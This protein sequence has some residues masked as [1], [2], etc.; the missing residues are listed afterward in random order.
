MW[1][2]GIAL[3]S[4]GNVYVSDEALNRV[5]VFSGKGEFVHCWGREGSGEDEFNRPAGIAFDAEDNLLVADGLNCRVQRYT[6]DGRRLGGWGRPGDADGEMNVPWGITVDRA[7]NVY[8]SDWRNDRIQKFGRRRASPEHLGNRR[9]GRRTA[10]AACRGR[11]RP[12]RRRIRGRLG[13]RARPGAGPEWR[14]SRQAPRR[15][16]AVQVGPGVVRRQPRRIRGEADRGHG[17][18]AGPA[19]LRLSQGPLGQHREAVLG[20]HRREGGRQPQ[21]LRRGQHEASNPGIPEV[22]RPDGPFSPD[23]DL[24]ATVIPANLV[25]ATLV[26]ARCPMPR[27]GTRRHKARPYTDGRRDIW[28]VPSFAKASP[29]G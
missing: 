8:V 24:C 5:S 23:G 27:A 22:R 13:E 20:A 12:G 6:R 4:D 14:V 9:P 2:A 28:P 7:G 26:V 16:R 15:L 11:R 19:V 1:P 17:A 29:G 25:G 3:D 21:G 18:P 10:P